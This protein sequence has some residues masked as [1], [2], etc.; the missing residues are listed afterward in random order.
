MSEAMKIKHKDLDKL[1]VCPYCSECIPMGETDFPKYNLDVYKIT[2]PCGFYYYT[3]EH[4][5]FSPRIDSREILRDLKKLNKL[6]DSNPKDLGVNIS[7]DDM[8][9]IQNEVH[10][11]MD[12]KRWR[13]LE[14]EI[15]NEYKRKLSGLGEFVDSGSSLDNKLKP[16]DNIPVIKIEP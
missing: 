1:R 12:K 2:C 7:L 13:K 9:D 16:Y 8:K 5:I 4:P 6:I 10:S 15:E 11:I 14:S 3:D